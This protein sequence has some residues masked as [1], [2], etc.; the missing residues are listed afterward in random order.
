MEYFMYDK[1]FLLVFATTIPSKR[2][3]NDV[4][5]KVPMYSQHDWA[6][7]DDQVIVQ[8][9][10]GKTPPGTTPFYLDDAF[11]DGED[12]ASNYEFSLTAIR[13]DLA[14]AVS[15]SQED[16]VPRSEEESLDIDTAPSSVC[17]PVTVRGCEPDH[18]A[19]I[20]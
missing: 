3:G 6:A 10:V 8:E 4:T 17:I 9:P 12:T 15:F 19:G 16:Q 5:C 13:A 11:S 7:D 20:L 18:L 14:R 2:E 1:S